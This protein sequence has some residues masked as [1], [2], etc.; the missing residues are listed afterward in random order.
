MSEDTEHNKQL[1]LVGMVLSM[2]CW[3]ISWTSG[4]IMSEYGDPLTNAFYRFTLTFISLVLIMLFIKTPFKVS[5]KGMPDMIIASILMSIYTF[6]FFKGLSTGKA[7]AGGVLVTVLNPIISYGIMLIMTKRKPTRNESLGLLLGLIA[8]V[9]LLKLITEA[10]KIFSAGNIYFLL[11]SFC[12]AILSIFTSRASRYGS[13]VTFSLYLSG[14]CAL[15]MFIFAGWKGIQVTFDKA[16]NI[17]WGNLFFSATITTSFATTMYF[18]ATSRLGPSKAS[19][20]IFLVPFS[21]ALGSWIFLKEIPQLH[22]I[23]GG[24]LGIGAVYVLNRKER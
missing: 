5:S 22:T 7:G 18:I 17:Y 24:L 13:S 1:F 20:F 11:A 23:I 19:S 6:L 14:I 3:G 9:I 12:W 4:K 8:G 21:A 15:L 2:I 10:D 16:D